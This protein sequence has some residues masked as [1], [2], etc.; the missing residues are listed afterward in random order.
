MSD[1]T[2]RAELVDVVREVRRRWRLKLAARGTAI[3]IGGTVLALL[4]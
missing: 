1:P 2:S 4:V 3:V